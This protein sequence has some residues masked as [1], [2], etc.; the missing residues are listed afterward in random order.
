MSESKGG[1]R[2]A[3][4][5]SF[6]FSYMPDSLKDLVLES[7]DI[8]AVI[9]ERISLKKQGKEYV[10]LC[11]FHA[12][13]KPS[14]SVSPQKQIFKCWSC[15]AGGDVFKFV[16]MRDKVSFREALHMLAERA[17]ISTQEG[18]EGD[19]SARL[20]DRMRQALSWA[21]QHF[22]R[23]LRNDPAGRY[24]LE[25]ARRRGLS[26][27]TIERLSLGFAPDA[28]S[29]LLD[30][31]RR[32]NIDPSTLQQ[33]GLITTS[34]RGKTY[35]RFRNRLIFPIGDAQGRPIAF[36]GRTMGD[37]PAKYLNSPESALFSKSRVL[38]GLDLARDA[39][40]SQG[41]VVVVE[42]Y[43]DVALLHQ[44]GIR[45]AVATLGTALTDAHVK[46]LRRWTDTILLCFDGDDAG[47][48]AADRAVETTLRSGLQVRVVLL[49]GGQDPADVVLESGAE[50]FDTLLNSAQEA[51]QFKWQLTVKEFSEA[52]PL[53]RQ[54]AV[55]TFLQS[56]AALSNAGSLDILQKGV[57]TGR[58]GELLG[59]PPN[60]VYEALAHA[61]SKGKLDSRTTKVVA[62]NG[63]LPGS[64]YAD[65]LRTLPS[66]LVAA[67]EDLAAL[68]L[69]DSSTFD[70]LDDTFAQAACLHPLWESF[71][72]NCRDLRDVEGSFTTEELLA[73]ADD[74]GTV[75][76]ISSIC[77][78]MTGQPPA[79][80]DLHEA[81]DRLQRELDLVQM[82]QLRGK[83]QDARQSANDGDQHFR[84]LLEAAR[85]QHSVL[86][87]ENRWR[88]GP[89]D[90]TRPI[91]TP[92]EN[93]RR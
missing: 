2:A 76:L 42:G 84:S 33:A 54:A 68:I 5:G 86:P 47:V 6:A 61:R 90:Q 28:W 32:V 52:D 58:L 7:T 19:R 22:Q 15:G 40:D 29:D 46:L 72:F 78:R 37:D 26:D 63:T 38:Y 57:L 91:T 43:M 24:A 56:I 89:S 60:D 14:M 87:A 45:E 79:E 59:I 9:G 77:G 12:D 49:P 3:L 48:R 74:G 31:A 34:E 64:Q 4:L 62:G 81:R 85:K 70:F 1:C 73:R 8:V 65:S 30:A 92:S 23:N 69:T 53:G 80:A 21:R 20:R 55:E 66:G 36:G 35:D 41:R 16:Q 10:G 44:F 39:I 67:L 71:Y 17:G 18:V 93:A 82:Q 88:L 27:E 51:L 13:H 75:Q 83:L 25:Y 50:G 11:P